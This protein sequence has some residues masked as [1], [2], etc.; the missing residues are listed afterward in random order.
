MVHDV[1]FIYSNMMFYKFVIFRFK[2]C[3]VKSAFTV[4]CCQL[5]PSRPAL[6][7]FLYKIN[8]DLNYTCS[9]V[10]GHQSHACH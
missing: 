3:T 8:C 10:T 9:K 7:V 5:K 1:N 2:T 6:L 4:T